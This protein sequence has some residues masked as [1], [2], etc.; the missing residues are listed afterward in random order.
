MRFI[1]PGVSEIDLVRQCDAL[2]RAAGVDDYWYRALPALVLAGEHTLTPRRKSVLHP[3]DKRLPLRAHPR[4]VL[5]TAR[6]KARTGFCRRARRSI[7]PP[8]EFV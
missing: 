5:A 4:P 3:G 2:Q 8:A 7:W 1:A 6:Q